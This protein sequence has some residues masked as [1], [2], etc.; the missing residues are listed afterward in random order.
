MNGEESV[1][2]RFRE[3]FFPRE[4]ASVRLARVFVGR[5]LLDWGIVV[6]MDDVLLC[7]S[8]LAA[9]AVRHGVPPGRGYG[10]RLWRERGGSLYLEVHDSGGGVPR[11]L[12]EPG[13][14]SGAEAD[15]GWGLVLV[16]ELSDRWGVAPRDSGRDPG[17]VVWCGFDLPVAAVP[18]AHLRGLPSG[19]RTRVSSTRQ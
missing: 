5:A 1:P 6:R 7:A 3:R 12:R 19:A 10:V 14:D 2:L 9:N 18:E 8:E 4:R 17:K 13:R 11:L 16:R 15:G